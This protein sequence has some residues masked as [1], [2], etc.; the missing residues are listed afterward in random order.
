MSAERFAANEWPRIANLAIGDPVSVTTLIE[1]RIK[2]FLKF[3]GANVARVRQRKRNLT[4]L[5][6]CR[7]RLCLGF[8][9]AAN[10]QRGSRNQH[11]DEQES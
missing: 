5:A 8:V 2:Q 9:D 11:D 1:E 7:L 3:R 4:A 10:H 6:G